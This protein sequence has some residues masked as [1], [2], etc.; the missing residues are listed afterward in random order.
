MPNSAGVRSRT[1]LFANTSRATPCCRRSP[2][3][4]STSATSSAAPSSSSSSSTIPGMGQLLIAGH[5]CRRL[6]PRARRHHDRDH[7]GRGRGVRDR[8]PLSADR[9]ARETGIARDVQNPPR[10]AALQPRVPA[11]SI[12]IAHHPGADRA[13]S[14]FSPYDENAIYRRHRPTCRLRP[15]TGSAPPRAARTCSGRSPPRLRNT[16]IVRHRRRRRQP[17][18]R[19]RRRPDL[20]LSRRARPTR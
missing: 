18:H 11:G 15:N 20:R 12:L 6:Q 9:S 3:W 14:F 8:H 10:P 16:L 1:H 5:L 19:A 17:H 7:R 13:L 4:R 2:A